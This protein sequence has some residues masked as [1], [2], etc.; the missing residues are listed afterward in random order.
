[1]RW[2]ALL[3]LLLLPTSFSYGQ[4]EEIPH[5]YLVKSKYLLNIPLF[6]EST[7]KVG[8]T[9]TIC[10][11]GDTPLKSIL[12]SSKGIMIRKLPLAVRTVEEMSQLESC[13]ML[14]IASSERY[15]LQI[16]LSEAH[17]QGILTIGDMRDFARSGGVIG[18]LT[19]DNRV[20]F[21]LNLSS[22]GK[23]SIS[24]SSHVL[25]LARDIIK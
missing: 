14:F 21:D 24:F 17:R 1:M 9:Y 18:L 13:Q 19:I 8:G 7:S 20:S 3:T 22:A 25:K 4:E 15:R 11:V 23:A 6:I 10:L 5:E 12:A 2:I 16:L